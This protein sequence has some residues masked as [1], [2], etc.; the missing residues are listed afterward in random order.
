MIPTI[1]PGIAHGTSAS[2]RASQRPR[3]GWLRSS[4]SPSARTN[5]IPVTPTAQMIPTLNELMNRSSWSSVRKLSSPVKVVSTF[6]PAR[7]SVKPR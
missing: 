2:E 5:W 3:N 7:A 6:R 4:A 1:T